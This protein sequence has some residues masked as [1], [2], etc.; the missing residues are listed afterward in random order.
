MNRQLQHY[1]TYNLFIVGTNECLS[2]FIALNS[3]LDLELR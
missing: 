2:S 3:G 1:L